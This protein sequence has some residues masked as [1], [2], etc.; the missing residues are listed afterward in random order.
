[1]NE[2]N[3]LNVKR[4]EI[5]VLNTILAECVL[6]EGSKESNK[7]ILKFYEKLSIVINEMENFQKSAI[8]KIKTDDFKK[9]SQKDP[10]ELNEKEKKEFELLQDKL[11]KK[12]NDILVSY[13]NED[14]EIEFENINE[15]DFDE[16][17]LVNKSKLNFGKINFISKFLCKK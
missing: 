5:N 9:L 2:K 16:F 4:N 3:V 1:M 11:N 6:G 15:D 13:F 8:E 12:L 17:I 10:V 7:S 14:C